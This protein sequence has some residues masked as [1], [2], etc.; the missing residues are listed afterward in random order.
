MSRRETSPKF[1]RVLTSNA[2]RIVEWIELDWT[3]ERIIQSL[4]GAVKRS[5]L[6]HFIEITREEDK[7][8]HT[9]K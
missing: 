8:K 3:E 9:K 7:T 1:S 6:R 4:G 5:E 2:E